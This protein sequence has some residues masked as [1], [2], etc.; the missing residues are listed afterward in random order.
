VAVALGHFREVLPGWGDAE[1]LGLLDA[2]EAEA[3]PAPPVQR[4]RAA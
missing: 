4:R 3:A 1:A 2:G